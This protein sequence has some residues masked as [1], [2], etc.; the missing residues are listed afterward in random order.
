MISEYPIV[1]LS[2]ITRREL[3][4]FAMILSGEPK[5]VKHFI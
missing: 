2:L 5:C 3:R 1:S 4:G